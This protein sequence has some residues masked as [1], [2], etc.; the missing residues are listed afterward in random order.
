MPVYNGINGSLP[1]NWRFDRVGNRS[2][3]MAALRAN[4][5]TPPTAQGIIDNF[6]SYVRLAND[7]FRTNLE[8]EARRR[9]EDQRRT[10]RERIASEE[11]RQQILSKLKV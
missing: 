8:Q 2:R 1:G 5:L 3:A 10:L 6:K 11:R 4:Y 9:E 7:R